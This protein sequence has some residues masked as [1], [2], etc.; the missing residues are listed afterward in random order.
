MICISNRFYRIAWKQCYNIPRS[1][2]SLFFSPDLDHSSYY[3]I[4]HEVALGM[5]YLHLRRPPILHLDL[6]S[7]N[8]LL[9]ELLHAKIADFGF[10]KLKLVN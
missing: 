6:K 1:K 5:N 3:Q 10:S 2:T 8:V 9:S 4:A 7:M